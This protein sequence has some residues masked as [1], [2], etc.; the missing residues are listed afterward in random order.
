MVSNACGKTYYSDVNLSAGGSGIL[1]S[2]SPCSNVS[3]STNDILIGGSSYFDVFRIK[4]PLSGGKNWL[5]TTEIGGEVFCGGGTDSYHTGGGYYSIDFDD[6]TSVGAQTDTPIYAVASGIVEE[7]DYAPTGFGNYVIIDHGNGYKTL[8]G[9][10]KNTA[11]VSETNTVALGEQIGIVGTTPG[12]PYSTGTHLHMQ[13]F[14][15]GSSASTVTE[16]STVLMEGNSLASYT[17]NSSTSQ[18]S[19]LTYYSSTNTP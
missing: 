3:Y 16:L 2:S 12:P 11:M 18:P 8:Y 6:L 9:H 17:V 14:Y 1:Y 5:L 19:C 15:G 4:H 13:L 10:M 7:V